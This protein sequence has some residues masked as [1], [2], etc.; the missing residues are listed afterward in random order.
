[1]KFNFIVLAWYESSGE[2]RAGREDIVENCRKC[3]MHFII[4]K[5]L[6]NVSCKV[7]WIAGWLLT[8]PVVDNDNKEVE[9]EG[10]VE[11]MC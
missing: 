4:L 7:I 11:I 9:E 1:M 2:R 6:F 3:F 10:K 8:F 5:T